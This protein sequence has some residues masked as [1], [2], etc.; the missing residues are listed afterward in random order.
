MLSIKVF[1]FKT[2]YLDPDLIQ[3]K[4]RTSKSDKNIIHYV[5]LCYTPVRCISNLVRGSK[6]IINVSNSL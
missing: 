5:T 3:N 1:S 4:H 6:Y 2:K